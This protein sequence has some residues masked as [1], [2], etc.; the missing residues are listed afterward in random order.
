MIRSKTLNGFVIIFV[1]GFTFSRCGNFTSLQTAKVKQGLHLTTSAGILTD[2]KRKGKRQG[3]DLVGVV[4]PSFGFGRSIGL[5]LGFPFGLYLEN[6]LNKRR[7]SRIF[8]GYFDYEDDREFLFLPYLKLASN[9]EKP[10]VV[11][12]IIDPSSVTLIYS[13]DLSSLTPY[14]SVKKM[15]LSGNPA[16]GDVPRIVSRYQE[17][18]QSIWVLGFGVEWQ[19]N[20]QPTLEIGVFRNS[21]Q[22]LVE[23]TNGNGEFERLEEGGPKRVFYDFFV[24]FKLTL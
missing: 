12:G 2:Q 16:V 10:D 11:A 23:F 20:F 21:Y 6:S 19:G 22:E 14:V 24:G 7:E 1:I 13:H 3:S 17:D 4:S 8:P 15:L 18:K 9:Q 5:E